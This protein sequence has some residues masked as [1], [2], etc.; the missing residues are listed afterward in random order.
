LRSQ[1]LL[2]A[3]ETLWKQLRAVLHE[4][5]K[6]AEAGDA[7][8][9]IEPSFSTF[10]GTVDRVRRKLEEVASPR[11]KVLWDAAHLIQAVDLADTGRAMAEALT[12][13]GPRIVLA[14]ANDVCLGLKGRHRSCRAATG[15]L[16]YRTL[17]T[18]LSRLS[19]DI[20][21][22]IEHVNKE[23]VPDAMNYLAQFRSAMS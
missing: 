8:L 15:R 18:L 11:L 22:R 16:D 4:P 3:S 6:A 21:L 14:H 5:V 1:P 9:A 2:D 7:L 23:E 12:S 20:A 19:R 10:V 17:V 13:F